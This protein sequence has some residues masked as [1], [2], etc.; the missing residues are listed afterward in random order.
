MAN[1]ETRVGKLEAQAGD[2]GYCQCPRRVVIDG[3]PGDDGK[4]AEPVE[5]VCSACGRPVQHIQLVWPGER[6]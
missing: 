3:W 2:A 6:V 5:T 4:P 1:L